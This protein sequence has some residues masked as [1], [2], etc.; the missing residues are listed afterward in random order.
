[1]RLYCTV[2][3]FARQVARPSFFQ[4]N[5]NGESLRFVNEKTIYKPVDK[6]YNRRIFTREG[7]A[8]FVFNI[9]AS[10]LI[11]ILLIAFLV[12][13]P[14]DLPKIGRALGRLARQARLMVEELKRESGLDEVESDL[15]AI[16]A[17]AKDAVKSVDVRPDLQKM[18]LDVNKEIR[19]VEKELS[20]KDFKSMYG[21][22]KK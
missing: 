16:E 3:A 17:Q 12:V 4:K 2:F 19:E 8:P 5:V 20:F 1:M 10:E 18:Q 13:G 15:K 9:G 11:V 21:G 14:K 6:A 7:G 22:G